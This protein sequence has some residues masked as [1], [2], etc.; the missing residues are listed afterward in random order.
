LKKGRQTMLTKLAAEERT[1]V[2]YESPHRL[3]KTLHELAKVCGEDR[4]AA[5]CRE[6]TKMFEETRKGA[7]SE[8]A[9]WYEAHPPKGEIVIVVAGKE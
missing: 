2:L 7:L 6:L 8:L 1:V 4:P 9:A 3:V 5:V